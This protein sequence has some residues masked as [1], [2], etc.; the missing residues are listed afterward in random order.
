MTKSMKMAVLP[1]SSE[2]TPQSWV[3]RD[4]STYTTFY[5]DM[6]NAFDNFGPLFDEFAGGGEEDVWKNDVLPG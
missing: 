4:I 1:N 3:P 2:F 5:I 6:L